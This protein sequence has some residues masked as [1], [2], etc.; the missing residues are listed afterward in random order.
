MDYNGFDCNPLIVEPSPKP[1]FERPLLTPL[2]NTYPIIVEKV[3]KVL[4][5]ETITTKAGGTHRYLDR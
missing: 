4:E 5:D 2:L 3:D 1:F